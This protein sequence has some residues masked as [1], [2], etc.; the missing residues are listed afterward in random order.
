MKEAGATVLLRE[1]GA[2]FTPEWLQEEVLVESIFRAMLA[3]SAGQGIYI[4]SDRKEI[5][6]E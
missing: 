6:V 5:P 3:I 4:R 2:Q 1:L